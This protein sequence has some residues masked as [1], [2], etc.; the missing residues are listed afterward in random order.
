MQRA[1]TLFSEQQKQQIAQAVAQ[2]E[3]KTSAEIIPAV[4]SAS[5]RYDR[6][7]DLVGLW[8]GIAGM[9]V[10]WCALPQPAREVGDWGAWPAWA[11]PIF[12]AG[13]TLGG[14]IIG[15]VVA[16]RVGWLRRLTTPNEEMADDVLRRAQH[17]FFD[18]RV[19]HTAG[20]TG[21]LIYVSLFE[22]MA[23]VVA[24]QAVLDKLGNPALMELRDRLVE[25]LRTQPPTE[26]ICAAIQAAGE[27][28]APILPRA[29][30]DVN[31]LSDALVTID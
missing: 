7:E 15:A 3:S 17:V 22:H 26:A 12:L 8:F 23:A 2:A 14:F 27:K 28:L 31:E 13:A 16:S 4:A 6:G 9:I 29:A 21:L 24:D 10:V 20:R 1:S 30:T 11:N 25:S 5:G 19:H 18:S